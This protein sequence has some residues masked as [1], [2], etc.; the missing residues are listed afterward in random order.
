MMLE[1]TRIK[2]STDRKLFLTIFGM[3]LIIFIF[4]NNGHRYSFDE[5]IVQ[6]QTM[7]IINGEPG[8]L[9][10][11]GNSTTVYEYP[12]YF[13]HP[14]GQACQ[15]AILCSPANVG[16]SITEVPFILINH[17]LHLITQETMILGSGDF[18]DPAYIY[19]RNS[20]DPDF[21]FLQLFYGPIFSAL[22]VGVFFLICRTFDFSYKVSILLS[23]LLG[24][25]TLLWP[26]SKTT[27][28]VVPD[29]FFIL[30]GFWFFRKFQLNKSSINLILCSSS[31][32]FGFLVRLDAVLVIIP[33][34]VYLLFILRNQNKKIKKFLSFVI[35]SIIS[36]VLYI[37]IN[38]LRY[39]NSTTAMSNSSPASMIPGEGATHFVLEGLLGL[40]FS[41]G[42]GLF[43]F[44]P[45]FLTAFFA[46]PDFYKKHKSESILFLS[47]ITIFLI[48]YASG[49]G[50]WWHGLV[51]WGPRYLVPIMP[52]LLIPLGSS[53]ENRKNKALRMIIITLAVAGFF[54]NLSYVIQDVSWF[55]WG[56]ASLHTGLYG[57]EK[58]GLYPLN[59][60]PAT[61]WTFEYSQLT[62]SIVTAFD[63]LQ[64]D[65]FLL[66]LFGPGI[67][68]IMFVMILGFLS[69]VLLYLLRR[70]EDASVKIK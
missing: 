48:Y 62:Q 42:V 7:Y 40:L 22:S 19:W 12:L 28:N 21:T 50:G 51:A 15:N 67:F 55:V 44:V 56:N 34:F 35:P 47:F 5:D 2:F 1:N 10:V 61:I 11:Q 37:T 60:H 13:P 24:T 23:L 26:Y 69:Y 20:I 8:K 59:I 46:F 3:M 70:N 57:I 33:L 36:Y 43:I 49:G 53:I 68:S 66:K 4:T 14:H 25:S 30:L 31:L 9:Y 18:D 65:I 38:F 54:F 6:K 58:N 45:I 41:P 16:F 17:N 64:P 27:M 52:F 32:G 39:G 29:L 63:H